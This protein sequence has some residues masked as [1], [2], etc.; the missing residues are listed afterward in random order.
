MAETSHKFFV[1]KATSKVTGNI[2]YVKVDY[3]Y[4]TIE[5]VKHNID[6]SFYNTHDEAEKAMK[7]H[8]ESEA[9]NTFTVDSI[10]IS[11]EEATTKH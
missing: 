11:L 7:K 1:I 2:H 3:D 9:I 6:G 5:L 8:C 4:E 10:I